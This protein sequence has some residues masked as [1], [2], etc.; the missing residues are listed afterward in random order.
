VASCR[1][2]SG[3]E[4]T[5]NGAVVQG[6]LD[7]D[8]NLPE[9]P[10]KNLA[11]LE[12]ESRPSGMSRCGPSLPARRKG[13]LALCHAAREVP[14]AGVAGTPKFKIVTYPGYDVIAGPRT[15]GVLARLRDR[16]PVMLSV[17]RR[18]KTD[19]P[20]GFRAHGML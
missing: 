20:T 1:M 15:R 6:Q 9:L 3:D 4:P 2:T 16:R 8:V 18:G 11:L 14:S 12:G 10:R 5:P 7:F 13:R 19:F 17:T